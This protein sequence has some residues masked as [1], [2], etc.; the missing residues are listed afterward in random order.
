MDYGSLASVIMW[1]I[2]GGICGLAWLFK[3]HG[4]VRVLKAEADGHIKLLGALEHRVNGLEERIFEELQGIRSTL[5]MM[6][7]Q[8]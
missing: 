5:N 6:A 7:R 2:G 3:L 4:D 8:Q 1:M